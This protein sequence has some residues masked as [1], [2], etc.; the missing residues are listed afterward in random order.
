VL[1]ALHRGAPTRLHILG[2]SSPQAPLGV[3]TAL[4]ATGAAA[5]SA[6]IALFTVPHNQPLRRRLHQPYE[7]PSVPE[8]QMHGARAPQHRSPV[9]SPPQRDLR[10]PAP[11][12]AVAYR[13][14]KSGVPP[15]NFN[16]FESEGTDQPVRE[17]FPS[18]VSNPPSQQ[19][20][21]DEASDWGDDPNR[22][23]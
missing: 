20:T 17:P 11:T 21:E 12:V 5:L 3:W 22:D 9:P 4:A 23:W 19:S 6:S 8:W 18:R 7:A 2:W 1:S 13:I 10:D 16:H 15:Q 14:I